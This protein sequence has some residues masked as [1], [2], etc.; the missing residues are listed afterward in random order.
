PD[1]GVVAPK[2]LFLQPHAELVFDDEPRHV[3]ADPRPLGR[4]L[5]SATLGRVDVLDR[6]VGPGIHDLE[7]G[8]LDGIAG[9][10]RWTAGRLP[11]FV[12]VADDGDSSVRVVANGEDVPIRRVV[13]LV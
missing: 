10:W 12:P 1:V 2:M 6:L 8:V 4:A 11:I 3:G 9:R 13:R 5:R 7:S